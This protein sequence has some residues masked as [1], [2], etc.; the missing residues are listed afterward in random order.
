[1]KVLFIFFWRKGPIKKGLTKEQWLLLAR[2]RKQHVR[3]LLILPLQARLVP[4]QA[5]YRLH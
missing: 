5:A 2:A 4:L 3:V 1:M